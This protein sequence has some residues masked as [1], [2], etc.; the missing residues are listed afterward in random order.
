MDR[1]AVKLRVHSLI[2]TVLATHF[3]SLARDRD[4]YKR[5]FRL[6]VKRLVQLSEDQW[7]DSYARKVVQRFI[8][9]L[10]GRAGP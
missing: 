7:N 5:V 4:R 3:S 10:H 9:A 2:K 1:S 6:A 8:E